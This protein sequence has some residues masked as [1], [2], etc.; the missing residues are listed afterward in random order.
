MNSHVFKDLIKVKIIYDIWH[1]YFYNHFKNVI[2]SLHLLRG[3]DFII[4]M[5]FC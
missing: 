2:E 5:V 1:I 3:L 4:I